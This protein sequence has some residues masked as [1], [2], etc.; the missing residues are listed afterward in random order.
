MAPFKPP[1]TGGWEGLSKQVM[2]EPPSPTQARR[3]V[4]PVDN[5]DDVREFLAS[6]R[7][8]ITPEQGGLPSFGGTRRVAGLRRAEVAMLAGV[9]PDYYSRL[10]RGN[11]SGVSEGVLNAIARALRLD[12]A[13]RSH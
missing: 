8:R 6:R 10:E 13:E 1:A 11:L 5:R 4:E 9:S 3:S 12:D 7:A 2:A